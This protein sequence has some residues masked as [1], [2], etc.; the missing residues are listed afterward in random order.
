MGNPVLEAISGRRSIR[1]YKPDQIKKEELEILLKAA[2]EAPSAAN[3]QPWHYSV[4]QNAEMIAEIQEESLKEMNEKGKDIFFKAPTVIFISCDPVS[5]WG[6]HDVGITAE[7]ICLAA[8]A[9]GLGTVML[10]RAEPAFNGPKG[11][12]F[13]KLLKFP[14]GYK[15]AVAIS[16]G[17][18]AG[19]KEAHPIAPGRIDYIE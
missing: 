16:V 5:R 9:I 10:G 12:H 3:L 8:H 11:D 15:Y 1:A 7:N 2:Q 13:A 17:Y 4:L 14:E 18:P 6:R 19:S